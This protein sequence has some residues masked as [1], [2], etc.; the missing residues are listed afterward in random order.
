MR[1][2][3]TKVDLVGISR[4]EWSKLMLTLECVPDDV[5]EKLDADGRSIKDVVVHRAH[6]ISLFLE[7]YHDG[8]ETIDALFPAKNYR[9]SE[10]KRYSLALR[11]REKDV[12]W[13]EALA[14]LDTAQEE[15]VALIDTLSDAQ[16]YG[17]PMEGAHNSW[18]TGRWA[19]AAGPSHLRL[20]SRYVRKR[21]RDMKQ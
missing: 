9:R 6:W 17:G 16:L 18:S 14:G 15:F 13:T 3:Q 21:L 2:A 5:A 1:V 12:S 10:L 19:E 11:E 4:A 7:C 20:A 8:W